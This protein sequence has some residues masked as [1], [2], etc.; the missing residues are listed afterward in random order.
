M[1]ATL[2]DI[3]MILSL[4]VLAGSGTGLLIGFIARK[5]K[6]DWAAMEKKDKIT[7]ILLIFLCSSV[8]MAALAWYL[9][10]YSGT[11]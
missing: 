2:F 5:Q 9:F 8:V 3:L 11:S 10:R 7:A 4:G 6:R 1:T